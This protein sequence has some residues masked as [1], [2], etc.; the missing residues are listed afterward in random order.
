ML[1]KVLVNKGEKVKK[2][3]QL[4]VIEA[5]KMETNVTAPMTG[6][7]KTVAVA[8]GDAVKVGQVLIEFE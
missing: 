7:L 5:M 3:Q 1:S 8:L 4:F 6:K 2:T